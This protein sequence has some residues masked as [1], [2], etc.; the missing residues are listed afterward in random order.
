MLVVFT[1][2][3]SSG[4]SSVLE[5]IVGR[6]FLPRGSGCSYCYCIGLTVDL[7]F[8]YF[9]YLFCFV[10]EHAVEI[11]DSYNVF[12]FPIFLLCNWLKK[13]IEGC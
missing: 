12:S 5:S 8:F 2:M 9:I 7:K 3:Q 11:E 1:K 13:N 4:K 10:A 6:D